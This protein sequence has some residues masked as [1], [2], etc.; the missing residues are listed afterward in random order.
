MRCEIVAVGTELLL[1]Q[2]VDTNSSWIGE[3]LAL[4]GIDSHFQTKVG[5]NADRIASALRIALDRSD[6]VIV[7]GGLGPTHDDITRD[8]IADVMGVE[9]RTDPE[10]ADRIR[11]MFGSRGRDMPDNNLRQAQVP[12]GAWTMDQQPGTA[13][14]LVCPIGDPVNGQVI[15]AVPGVPY[16]MKEM[17]EGSVIPDLQRRA[18]VQAVIRSRTLRTWGYSESG[19]AE[20]LAGRIDEL[21]A[22]GHAT[23]AFLASGME[24][25]KVRVT[26]KASTDDEAERVL[27][28]EVALIGE[29][30]G[31]VVFSTDD[32]SMEEVVLDL[33]RDRGLTQATAESVTGGQIASR[34]TSHPGAS[35]VFRG[36]VVSYASEVKFDVLGV[37]VGPV[38]SDEAAIAMAEGAC[39][40]LGADVAVSVTG[41]A[42]PDPQEGVPVGTVY[43]G[44]CIDGEA[45]SMMIRLP[46][47]RERVRQFSTISVLDWLRRRLL[48][49]SAPKPW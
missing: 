46:G 21:D 34:L 2:I 4:A 40:V 8:V 24:G 20:L 16:E 11:A 39:R 19:L 31:E 22:M 38:V 9:L 10:I 33:H 12:V 48:A 29:V 6:A 36:S 42:G 1:G 43:L 28:D 32:Q 25:L 26:A 18:G 37:P 30:L 23:I 17:V 35:E 41:V 49:Q 27:A 14:G 5:D 15:Y 45:E 3:Q 47:D 7:C 13:P 44:V